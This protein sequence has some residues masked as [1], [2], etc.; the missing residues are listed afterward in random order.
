[1]PTITG[2]GAK[3]VT[4]QEA[5]TGDRIFVHLTEAGLFQEWILVS[6]STE[7]RNGSGVSLT[8]VWPFERL[9]RH[10]SQG[11]K[12]PSLRIRVAGGSKWWKKRGVPAAR[13][14]G[15]YA[16]D[17]QLYNYPLNTLPSLLLTPHPLSVLAAMAD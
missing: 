5:F 17:E 3:S 11:T 15:H 12:I 16:F 14:S 1:M 10:S 7:M 2:Q 9:H 6:G 4:I 13:S 8:A